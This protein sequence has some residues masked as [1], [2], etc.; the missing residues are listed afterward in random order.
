MMKR[1]VLYIAWGDEMQGLIDRSIKS[2]RQWHPDMPFCVKWLD[3]NA[4]LL[5]KSK[6]LRSAFGDDV[7]DHYLHAGEWEQQ[8]FDRRVTDY[9]RVRMFERG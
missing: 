9:E 4:S 2:L 8:E 6:I 1:G 5:D 3:S 7:I